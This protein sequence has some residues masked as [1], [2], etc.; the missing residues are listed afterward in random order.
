[1]PVVAS[2]TSVCWLRTQ[3]SSSLSLQLYFERIYGRLLVLL[4]PLIVI[5]EIEGLKNF[6]LGVGVKAA[7]QITVC[8]GL[9]KWSLETSRRNI[10]LFVSDAYFL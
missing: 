2:D 8:L 7:E 4:K 5:P 1:M 10:F 6:N 3:V 9:C